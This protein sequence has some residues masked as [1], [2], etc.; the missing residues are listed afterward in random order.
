M[1]LD[2]EG[3]ASFE[4]L[5][6][7]IKKE[8]DKSE[9]KYRSL[10]QKY[11]KLQDSFDNSQSQK[12]LHTRGQRGASN[13]KKLQK[14]KS[15]TGPKPTW[16]SNNNKTAATYR[17][18]PIP[19]RTARKSRRY[20]QRYYKRQSHKIK[21]EQAFTI[22]AEEK[23]FYHR[24]DQVATAIKNKIKQQFGF[25]ADPKKTLLHN[26]SST[27]ATTPTW[28]YSSRP[29]HLAFHDFT[30][31]KQPTKNLRS[32][33]GL[34]LKFIPTSCRTNTLTKLKEI[35]M[36]K[37]QRA[38]HLRFHFAG[39]A[40]SPNDTYDPKMYVRS[41]WTPPYWTLPPVVLQE[42]LDKFVTTLNKL[43]KRRMGKTNLLSYQ[44]R[45]LQSLQRQQDFLICPCDKNLGPAI[46]ERDDYIKIAMRDH[47]LDGCTYRQL[48][49]A[50]CNNHKQRLMQEIKSW[51]KQYNKT[52]PKMERAFLKQGLDQN[53]RAF[54]GFYLTLKA[55]KLK[56]GQSVIH[57]KSHP[58]V[59]CPGSLLHPL[60]IWTNRK[61]QSLA[62]QQISYFRNCFDLCQDLCSTQYPTT[63]Q[64]FTADA[65][66]MYTNIPTN[67][68][69]MLIARHLRK[70]I[71]EERPKQN[72]A[73]IA[74]LKLVMLNNIFSF[75]N[76]TFKQ[77]NGTTMGTPPAPPP[78]PRHDLL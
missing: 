9:K 26:A 31:Q 62:K 55:H 56:S 16:S 77:L 76:M 14:I 45:A 12:N 5:Q 48:S 11:N 36:P 74:A 68:A 65:I 39:T 40:S 43:F 3:G 51:L 75:G 78:P 29:S 21:R 63:A 52:L 22:A 64:L 53:K 60:G 13:K 49:E 34:G 8:C 1:E 28:Y 73:L 69:I 72:E 50:D 41:N 47:L 35:S 7:L 70:N 46:I 2:A 66:S 58:I 27:L 38:I 59:S 67:T 25:V 61:L 17:S 44:T 57:P 71:P 30:Q 20:Q 10:E 37:L 15:W 23:A 18:S 24:S 33:L 19:S 42:R 4:Q 54:A 6:D 32:L